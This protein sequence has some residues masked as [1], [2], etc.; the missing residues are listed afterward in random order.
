MKLIVLSLNFN[1]RYKFNHIGS[2]CQTNRES[3]CRKQGMT[4]VNLLLGL[5]QTYQDAAS[6]S[7]LNVMG[8]GGSSLKGTVAATI[9]NLFLIFPLS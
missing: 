4:S 3:H 9:W 6:L 8:G 5:V 1:Q 7:L 2:L